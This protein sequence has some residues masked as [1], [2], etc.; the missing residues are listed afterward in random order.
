MSVEPGF[1]AKQRRKA[2]PVNKGKTLAVSMIGAAVGLLFFCG[3]FY[4]KAFRENR[5]ARTGYESLREECLASSLPGEVSEREKQ[6]VSGEEKAD[7]QGNAKEKEKREAAE[8]E[9]FEKE[10]IKESFGIRWDKLREINPE[11]VGWIT[12]SGADISYPVVQ[13][14]D[15]EYYLHHSVSGEEDPFGTIFLGCK[16]GKNLTDSHSFIYGHNMEGNLMFANLNRYESKEFLGQCPVF[17]VYTPPQ[18]ACYEIFSVEQAGETS[19]G[20]QYGYPLGS[21][22]YETQ[23]GMLL[24]NSMYDTGV[25]PDKNQPMVTLVTCNSRL[26]A[27][28]RMTIH[29][30]RRSVCTWEEKL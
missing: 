27:Q 2:E 24:E 7:I 6:D 3:S 17:Y 29:G 1:T 21:W 25:M 13:G 5:E 23:L 18:M 8:N 11:I 19:P 28:V 20:F 26:D 16:S 30:I 4:V 14:E 10:E 9:G 22:E 15:D 12:V